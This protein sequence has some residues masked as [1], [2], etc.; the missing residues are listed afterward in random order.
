M[1]ASVPAKGFSPDE[2]VVTASQVCHAA[3]IQRLFAL[4]VVFDPSCVAARGVNEVLKSKLKSLAEAEPFRRTLQSMAARIRRLAR[5][6]R[7]R[8]GWSVAK[9]CERP[10]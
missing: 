4:A 2:A 9:S 1:A 7:E 8:G 5:L 6:K 10:L 3:R